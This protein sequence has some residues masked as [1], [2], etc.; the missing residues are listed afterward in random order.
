[1]N[2]Q[3]VETNPLSFSCDPDSPTQQSI[4]QLLR[5]AQNVH[6]ENAVAHYLVG[7]TLQIRFPEI[8]IDNKPFNQTE[9][10]ISNYRIGDT[11]FY[12]RANPVLD[13]SIECHQNI[14]NPRWSFPLV[15]LIC[16]TL[17]QILLDSRK[18]FARSRGRL[19]SIKILVAALPSCVHQ[20]PQR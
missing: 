11:D 19:R 16:I 20:C 17:C 9:K 18:I 10:G 5:T 8:R 14:E 12:V 4:P 7:A 2:D 1:M 13:T 15:K 6:K 3:P